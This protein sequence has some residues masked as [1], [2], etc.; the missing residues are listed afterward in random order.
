MQPC[1]IP[2]ASVGVATA[3]SRLNY[4]QDVVFVSGHRPDSVRINHA[5]GIGIPADWPMRGRAYRDQGL[6]GAAMPR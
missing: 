1:V 5:E 4:S 3:G 2:V 6:R